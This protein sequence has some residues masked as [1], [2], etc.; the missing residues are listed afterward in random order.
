MAT[1]VQIND[2]NTM[3]RAVDGDSLLTPKT[4]DAIVRAVLQAVTDQE[5][6]A[7]RVRAETRVTGGVA[8]EMEEE[9]R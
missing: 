8:H 9:D 7:Q 3:V 6:H 4:M 1:E 5:A 2:M